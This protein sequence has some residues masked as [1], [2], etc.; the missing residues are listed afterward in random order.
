MKGGQE[1]LLIPGPFLRPL[2][3]LKLSL[4]D[5][6]LGTVSFRQVW[7]RLACGPFPRP[8]PGLQLCPA[9]SPATLSWSLPICS[10][11]REGF[12]ANLEMA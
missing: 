3:A 5:E 2:P 7:L 11:G 12:V 1:T 9:C 10:G 4:Q 8:C 6:Q